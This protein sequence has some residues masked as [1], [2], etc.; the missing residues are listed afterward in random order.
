MQDMYCEIYSEFMLQLR[1]EN[2]R[3]EHTHDGTLYLFSV[4]G[5]YQGRFIYPESNQNINGNGDDNMDDQTRRELWEEDD[6]NR[7]P[8]VLYVFTHDSV[9]V[10][11][12]VGEAMDEDIARNVMYDA[13]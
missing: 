7:R 2:L 12:S 10:R 1:E 9:D 13:D 4:D 3:N 8:T 5:R 11:G 6:H